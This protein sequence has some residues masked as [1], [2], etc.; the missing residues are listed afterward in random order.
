VR[1]DGELGQ[2][3]NAG[4]AS[5][6]EG[7][8]GQG[9][10]VDQKV[11]GLDH[12]PIGGNEVPRREHDDIPRHDGARGDSLFKTVADHSACQR[13]TALELLDRG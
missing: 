8:I 13:Q 12:E 5:R 9:A 3:R 1:L 6:R 10:F 2:Q 11:L 7:F 4:A